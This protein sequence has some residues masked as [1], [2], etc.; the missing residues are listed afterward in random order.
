MDVY[1]NP[2]NEKLTI[3]FSGNVMKQIDIKIFNTLGEAIF[4]QQIPGNGKATTLNISHFAEG[5]YV[6]R[7]TGKQA[8]YD[9]KIIITR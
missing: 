5:V 1:P 2:A 7:V 4:T 8:Y 6:I 3:N 9:R